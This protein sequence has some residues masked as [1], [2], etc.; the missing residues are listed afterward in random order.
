MGSDIVLPLLQTDVARRLTED[1]RLVVRVAFAGVAG[2]GSEGN[3]HGAQMRDVIMQAVEGD[4]PCGLIID[5]RQLDYQ[6]GDWIGACGLHSR[7]RSCKTCLVAV[8]RTS[9][10]LC[11]FWETSRLNSLVPVFQDLESAEEYVGL[12]EE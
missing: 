11:P 1:G 2:I 7:L 10:S 6:F 3:H 4:E 5:L 9:E 12:G 8:G